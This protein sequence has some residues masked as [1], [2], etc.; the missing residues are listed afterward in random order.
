MLNNNEIKE[1]NKRWKKCDIPVNWLYLPP[2]ATKRAMRARGGQDSKITI[3]LMVQDMVTNADS[4][5]GA[6]RANIMSSGYTELSVGV[7]VQG[8]TVYLVLNSIDRQ[9]VRALD[10]GQTRDT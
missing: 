5:G 7:A 3:G 6:N 4:N 8:N 10:P 1:G 2:G 9:G